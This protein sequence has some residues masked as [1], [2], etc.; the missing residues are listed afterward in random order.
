MKRELE[1]LR[2][3]DVLF[4]SINLHMAVHFGLRIAPTMDVVQT[5][6]RW[7]GKSTDRCFRKM[8]ATRL[9]LGVTQQA[10]EMLRRQTLITMALGQ[11]FRRHCH[12]KKFVFSAWKKCNPFT[13]G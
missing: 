5:L 7:H 12:S 6:E 10:A 13:K 3:M 11:Q 1:E 8:R 4:T 9:L 2:V